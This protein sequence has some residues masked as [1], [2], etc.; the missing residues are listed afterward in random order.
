MVSA[1]HCIL[2]SIPTLF[3]LVSLPVPTDSIQ[4]QQ[5]FAILRGMVWV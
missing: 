1:K 2:L 5:F 3:L 4:P